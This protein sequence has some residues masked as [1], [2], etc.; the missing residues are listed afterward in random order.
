MDANPVGREGGRSGGVEQRAFSPSAA[1]SDTA[2]TVAIIAI[3]IIVALAAI[4]MAHLN[5]PMVTQALQNH[6]WVQWVA[7][8]GGITGVVYKLGRS[9]YTAH[10]EK[11]ALRA[12]EEQRREQIH[13]LEQRVPKPHHRATEALS[14][15]PPQR[16]A[17]DWISTKVA[18]QPGAE[19]RLTAA[20]QAVG[21]RESAIS[22]AATH[23]PSEVSTILARRAHRTQS[24]PADE[25]ALIEMRFDAC[26]STCSVGS[27]LAW[28]DGRKEAHYNNAA[29]I[30]FRWEDGQQ[31]VETVTVQTECFPEESVEGD[32]QN[33]RLGTLFPQILARKLQEA[34]AAKCAEIQGK[35]W[36]VVQM[37]SSTTTIPPEAESEVVEAALKASMEELH[38]HLATINAGGHALCATL[39]FGDQVYVVNVGGSRAMVT[40]ADGPGFFVTQPAVQEVDGVNHPA[41]LLGTESPHAPH[42]TRFPRQP[43]ARLVI[44]NKNFWDVAKGVDVVRLTADS[45]DKGKGATETSQVLIDAALLCRETCKKQEVEAEEMSVAADRLITNPRGA[46]ASRIPAYIRAKAIADKDHKKY[47]AITTRTPSVMVVEF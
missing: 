30:A 44:G 41:T 29:K 31:R 9:I 19:E 1:K 2:K 5:I 33:S 27:Q 18:L 25:A 39:T 28:T 34:H 3:P 8:F 40:Q 12:G 26:K 10:Q 17:E 20:R 45:R 21:N 4:L 14:V 43:G 35:R 46:D 24:R 23:F 16:T 7:G 37:L 11:K 22:G 42:I 13:A 36:S 15:L 47:Q 6:S 38:Q 32:R